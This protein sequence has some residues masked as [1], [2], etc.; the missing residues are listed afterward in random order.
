MI[1]VGP[2]TAWILDFGWSGG[3]GVEGV[4]PTTTEIRW[5]GG[6]EMSADY[7]LHSPPF[8]ASPAR[9]AMTSAPPSTPSSGRSPR[10]TTSALRSGPCLSSLTARSIA[11]FPTICGKVKMAADATPKSAIPKGNTHF[12]EGFEILEAKR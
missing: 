12:D 8:P 1:V 4:P 7:P 11:L 9:G 3:G 10:A 6:G 2:P 5:G